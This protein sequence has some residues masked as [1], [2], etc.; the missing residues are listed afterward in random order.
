MTPDDLRLFQRRP[1][2]FCMSVLGEDATVQDVLDGRARHATA[3]TGAQIEIMESV[4]DNKYTAVPS[5]N[6]QGKSHIAARVALWFISCHIPSIVIFT[7]PKYAQVK[8]ILFSRFRQAW[9]NSKT[10]LG[11]ECYSTNFYPARDRFPTWFVLGMTAK[12]TNCLL[13][14]S[15]S[16][17]D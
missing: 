8:D 15:P 1:D 7:A 4:R 13:Y 2:L 16:P 10:D 3:P 17:R 5:A 9:Q 12:S 11:G 6:N 14:T